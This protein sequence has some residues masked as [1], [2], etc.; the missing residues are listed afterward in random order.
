MRRR[1]LLALLV[2]APLLLSFGCKDDASRA[3]DPVWGKQ[4]CE[5]CRMIV[6]DRRSAA[7]LVTA[8]GDRLYF[9]D[10]GCMIAFLADAGQG[11]DVRAWAR[12]PAGDGWIDAKT[13]RY[14]GGQ[15]TPMDFGFTASAGGELDFEAMAQR[16]RARLV[17]G[18]ASAGVA[19]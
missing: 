15:K 11:G 18:A 17:K 8:R 7:Q 6:D 5:H 12:D 10:L 19:P 14:S 16:V 9:D 13:A 2:A 3:I 1:T 4:P